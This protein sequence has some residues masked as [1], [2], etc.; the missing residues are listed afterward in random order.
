MPKRYP[1]EQRERAVRMVLDHLDEYRSVY[2]AC[3]VI[4]P[5]LGIGAESLR[6]WTKQAQ[7][8]ANEVPG[9]TSTEPQRIKDLER[10]NRE[11][12]EANE[13]D[14]FGIEFLREGTRPSPP[15]GHLPAP[16]VLGGIVQ[17]IDNMRAQDFRVESICRVL[18][19]QGIQVA[20]RTYR[21]WKTASPSARMLTDAPPHRGTASNDRHRG[22]VVRPTKNDRSPA[23]QRPP[24]RGL[25]HRPLDARRRTERGGQG[26][27]APNHN[28]G[29][30]GQWAGTRPAR[31]RFHR[32]LTE[33]AHG[34]P[35]SPIAE[36]GRGSST[37]HS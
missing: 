6:N 34:L 5:K 23:P 16:Q 21:N 14:E 35:I 12:K 4:G 36:H 31:S 3:Q 22:R 11:L 37:S 18:T 33:T 29:R 9:A 27:T 17:F 13:I 10:E 19:A 26:Q 28:S 25:H 20:P 32:R 8:D 7:I 2:S 15:R 1:P 30:Q 24:R